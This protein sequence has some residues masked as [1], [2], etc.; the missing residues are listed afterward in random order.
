VRKP[1]VYSS[2]LRSLDK[3]WRG[4]RDLVRSQVFF[5]EIH[6]F[7]VL[8]GKREGRGVSNASHFFRQKLDDNEIL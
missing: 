2:G 6:D 5:F 7:L 4:D 1:K 3:R 8:H